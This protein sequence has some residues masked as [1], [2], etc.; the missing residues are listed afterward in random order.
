[1][2][3][4]ELVLH[5][6][7]VFLGRH[8][9]RLTTDPGRPVVLVGGMNGRGKTTLLDALQ[10]ALYG[11]RSPAVRK[12]GGSYDDYLAS[13]IHHSARPN[14]ASVSLEFSLVEDGAEVIY[15]VERVWIAKAS[16]AREVLTVWVNGMPDPVAAERWADI[17]EV[18]LP[19]EI[20]ELF[21]FDGEKIEQLAD[22]NTAAKVIEAAVHG[23]LGVGLVER[24]QRDLTALQRRWKV[25]EADHDVQEKVATL[26]ARLSEL[27]S[28]REQQ[29]QERAAIQNA[30]DDSLRKLAEARDDFT[31]NGGDL[32]AQREDIEQELATL[33]STT[34]RLRAQLVDLASGPLPFA[35][36]GDLVA[37]ARQQA[38][39]EQ[40]A[41]AASMTLAVLDERDQ[42]ILDILTTRGVARAEVDVVAKELHLD[43]Q[44]RAELGALLTPLGLGLHGPSVFSSALAAQRSDATA[45]ARLIEELALVDGSMSDAERRLDA[46]PPD[47]VVARLSSRML[48]AE[49][50]ANRHGAR[51]ALID[52][53][54]DEVR[55]AIEDVEG[56]L[57]RILER[58]ASQINAAEDR[59]RMHRH[60]DRAQGTLSAF[61]ER[62]VARQLGVIEISVLRSFQQLLGKKGLVDNLTISP[63]DFSITLHGANDERLAPDRLSAGERQLLATALLW[64]LARASGRRLPMVIDTPLGRL[65]SD[66]RRK[67]VERYFPAASNQMLLL[68]TDEEI[69]EPLLAMLHPHI[70]RT[71]LLSYD[72]TTRATSIEA[73]YFWKVRDVA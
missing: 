1:M 37:S 4:R 20:A 49:A 50:T 5:N 33:T 58:Y 30:V 56:Q 40:A 45:A 31:R 63:E 6:V 21:L 10:L 27:S 38:E 64:G 11:R 44:E 22:P 39:R 69:D 59:A 53:Q 51:I 28:Q 36:V 3:L 8:R 65:D 57:D 18:L 47:A 66:H 17:A 42:R 52:E 32:A 70:S 73:G 2:H 15:K 71:Y 48:E 46:V 72:D 23:L 9:V 7:G 24:L 61:R 60:A 26:Q 55:R 35:L 16:G 43:R 19:V 68:S 67:L 12:V 14:E 25:E 34:E 41:T 29:V 13:L 62:M 54:L